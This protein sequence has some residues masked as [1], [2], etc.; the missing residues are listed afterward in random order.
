VLATYVQVIVQPALVQAHASSAALAII[1]IKVPVYLPA[2][3]VIMKKVIPAYVQESLEIACIICME[4]PKNIVLLPCKHMCMCKQCY[5][6]SA[7]TLCPICRV[8][9]QSFMEIYS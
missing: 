5:E 3:R 8:V 7:L 2:Q 6:Q 9:V 1:Y 4:N